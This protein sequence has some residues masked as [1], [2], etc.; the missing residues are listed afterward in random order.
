MVSR[1]LRFLN[2]EQTRDFFFLLLRLLD[3]LDVTRM[4]SHILLTDFDNQHPILGETELFVNHV[5]S[6][7]VEMVLNLS[8]EKATEALFCLLRN[9][10][11]LHLIKTKIGAIMTT[12]LLERAA[13][14]LQTEEQP[15]E[16][17]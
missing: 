12:L 17:W 14:S 11:I 10:S 9:N 7:L 3:G 5:I 2:E 8:L 6:P 13:V 1:M 4:T 16:Q 15:P